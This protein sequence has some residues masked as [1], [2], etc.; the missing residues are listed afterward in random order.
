MSA[1]TCV[2]PLPVSVLIDYWLGDLAPAAEEEGVEEHLLGCA[3]CSE[4]L[5]DLVTL[6][7]H[8]ATLAA[9]GVIRVVVTSAF[10]ESLVAAGFAVREYQLVPG[11]SVQC[12]VTP[13]DDV[14]AAHLRVD[15]RDVERVDLVSCDE[16]GREGNRLA[17]IP[18]NPSSGE[19]VLLERTD[20]LRALPASVTRVKLVSH[21]A[22][23]ERLLGEYTF[24]HTPSAH[25]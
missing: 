5:G 25:D 21:E 10:L 3:S 12:I 11:G 6:T 23:G 19:V 8:V 9:D 16:E 18:V 20:Q 2:E 22:T 4:R 24:V 7:K 14:V 1:A 13:A 15:L 17:D